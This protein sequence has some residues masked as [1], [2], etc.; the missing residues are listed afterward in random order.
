MNVAGTPQR[1][2][3]GA[4]GW[5]AALAV[6]TALLATAV[7]TGV[8]ATPD[9]A[10]LD[11]AQSL[12]SPPLDTAMFSVSLLGA[13]EVT[14]PAMFLLCL[15]NTGLPLLDWRR[16]L[17]FTIMAALVLVEVAAKQAVPDVAPPAALHRGPTF[18][19]GVATPFSFPSGHMVR[20]TMVLGILAAR[21]GRRR[22]GRAWGVLAVAVLLVLGFSRVYLAEHWPADVL[23]GLLLG[24]AG[25]AACLALAPGPPPPVAPGPL[26]GEAPGE[27]R[28]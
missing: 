4:A 24:A 25:L 13:V 5:T 21:L 26:P 20:A 10:L 15:A 16:W 18:G 7:G 12:A 23:G 1:R 9:R 6:M 14:I 2:R 27:L 11:L 17:P 8:L 22:G 19:V 3:A 28:S